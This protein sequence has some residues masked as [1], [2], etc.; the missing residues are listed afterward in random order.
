MVWTIFRFVMFCFSSKL[1][2]LRIETIIIEQEFIISFVTLYY[3]GVEEEEREIMGKLF[4][5]ACH[6][7]KETI[8]YILCIHLLSVIVIQIFNRPRYCSLLTYLVLPSTRFPF[9][10]PFPFYN[11]YKTTGSI[12]LW[13]IEQEGK[14]KIKPARGSVVKT[15]TETR[16]AF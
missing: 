8:R 13:N 15:M 6:F 9:P 5:E 7:R 11:G 1:S 4:T 3:A 16:H 14:N 10:F 12:F 2:L